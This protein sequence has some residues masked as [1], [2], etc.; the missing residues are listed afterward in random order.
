MSRD[1]PGFASKIFIHTKRTCR[2]STLY[3]CQVMRPPSVHLFLL[4][5][6]FSLVRPSGIAQLYNQIVR[7]WWVYIFSSSLL[8]SFGSVREDD[9]SFG[10]FFSLAWIRKVNVSLKPMESASPRIP[11]F[12][13]AAISST[14]LRCQCITGGWRTET[15]RRHSAGP[16]HCWLE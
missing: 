6:A 16:I 13:P 9:R 14:D 7:K 3:E 10:F 12:P 4:V 5:S 15:C 8:E 1:I 2:S 11:T